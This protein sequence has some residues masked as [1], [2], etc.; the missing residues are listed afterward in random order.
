[1]SGDELDQAAGEFLLRLIENP[2]PVIA[3]STLADYA[4][5][6]GRS[7]IAAE[8]LKPDGMVEALTDTSDHDDVPV[9]LQFDA[10][11]SRY[12]YVG[13]AG[14]VDV[15]EE[16]LRLYRADITALVRRLSFR[17]VPRRPA[18][19]ELI[20]GVLYDIG[21]VQLTGASPTSIWFGRRCGVPEVL[22]A[23]LQEAEARPAARMRLIVTST[24]RC[25]LANPQT[26]ECLFVDCR[27]ACAPGSPL[28]LDR[29]LLRAQLRTRNGEATEP[30]WLSPDGERLVILGAINVAFRSPAQIAVIRALVNGHKAGKRFAAQPLLASCGSGRRTFREFFGAEKWTA[31]SPYLKCSDAGWGFD[32]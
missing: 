16:R 24:A 26:S 4:P 19:H 3:A 12:G 23:I 17:L 5:D 31:L 29:T 9:T 1:M 20:E 32:V 18:L 14:W 28:V 8:L 15:P 2:E 10:D 7:L 11:R 25:E 21:D 13:A 22:G 6:A 27:D 30:I